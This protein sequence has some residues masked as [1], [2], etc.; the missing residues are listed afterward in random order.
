MKEFS[1]L[2]KCFPYELTPSRKIVKNENVRAAFLESIYSSQQKSQTKQQ[3]VS[4]G[5][6]CGFP[7]SLE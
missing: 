2:G 6:K 1:A 5:I 4:L 7:L 3:I